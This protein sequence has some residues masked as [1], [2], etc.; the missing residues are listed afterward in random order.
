MSNW[1]EKVVLITGGS[2]G[3]GLA[4]AKA[5]AAAGSKVVLV[6]RNQDRLHDAAE[7]L[8]AAGHNASTIAADVTD[9]A[10]VDRLFADVRAQF[11][12]LDLLVNNAGRSHRGRAIDTSVD[13]FREL[14]ELNFLATVRCTQAAMPL[15]IESQGHLVNIASLAGKTVSPHLGAYPASKF[16]VAAYSHQLRL[17]M[18]SDGVHVLLVCPGPI[19]RDDAGSRYDDLAEDKDIPTAAAKPGGGVKLRGLDPARLARQVVRACQRRQSELI[20]PGKARFLLA[21]SSLWPRLGDWVIGKMT[22]DQ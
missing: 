14:L 2:A 12:R 13:E 7:Q 9:Q 1:S 20:V 18:K 8:R 21:I 4:L 11:G 6:G 10:D 15:L 3:F 5:Y 17:E 19:A 22:S 16:P